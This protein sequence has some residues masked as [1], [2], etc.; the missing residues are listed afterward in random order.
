MPPE[1]VRSLVETATRRFAVAG[2]ETPHLDARILLTSATGLTNEQI[3]LEPQRIVTA[4][5]Q[6]A[7]LAAVARREAREP[8]SRIL[9]ERE[10]YGRRFDITPSVLD[11]R[12]DTETLIDA[13]LAIMPL[14]ARILDLGT[15]SGAI[16][17]TLLAE[18]SDATGVGTDISRSALAVAAVNARALGVSNR[19]QLQESRWFEE[20]SG[21]YD[22]I[23]SN[24]P[25]IP[26]ADIAGLAPDV[27]DFDPHLALTD[28]GDGLS[29]Y[30]AIATG[31]DLHLSPGG[32][33]MVEIGAGQADAVEAI[34]V[35]AGFIPFR[36]FFDLGGHARGLGFRQP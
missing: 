33:V 20:V 16:L 26:E 8:V 29:A 15:G 24:P 32:T 4:E 17:V 10:F 18:R 35:G 12:P 22:V 9:G 6:I 31:A 7:F 13:V 27:R 36:R 19:L 11:P 28:G 30:R 14:G 21:T 5:A 25:Y 2:C 3:I 23:V 1:T 34:F